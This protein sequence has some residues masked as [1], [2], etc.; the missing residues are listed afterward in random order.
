M[1]AI[2]ELSAK[3]AP[4]IAEHPS[5][6]IM[7]VAGELS[8]DLLGAGLMQELRRVWPQLRFIGIGG[9]KMIEAGL[10][11]IEP[12]ESLSV[13]GLVEVVKVLPK[14]L[15]VR[16]E[17]LKVME[18]EAPIA[19]I[20]IDSPDFNL[21]VAKKIDR[22]EGIVT[23]QYV[24]PSIW[25]WREGRVKTI[26]RVIDRVLCLFPFEVE[27]YK[28]HGVDAVCVGHRM[29]DEIPLT[30]S[31][32]ASALALGIDA[33]RPYIALLPGSRRGE[34]ER[35]L[36]LF[37]EG[38]WLFY[39]RKSQYNFLIPAATP[40][41]YQMIREMLERFREEYRATFGEKIDHFME[42]L[43]LIEGGAREAMGS[44]D[45]VL[46]ASGTASL[47]A[48]LLKKPMV[49]AYRFTPFTAWI[50]PKIVKIR[51]FS[52]PNILAG[53][54][55]VPELFQEMVTAQKIA[56][57]LEENILEERYAQLL[58][59]F[60]KLHHSLRREADRAAANAVLEKILME[61]C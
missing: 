45:A 16:K 23:F 55:I 53:R 49:V 46:L 13:M 47:E 44:A 57:L 56:E 25:V 18:Q 38:C 2:V 17:L 58:P 11:S 3:L 43:L 52:L 10:E 27:L 34:V 28:K 24:S 8:G 9:P 7:L 20:G 40:T 54:E 48:M 1:R 59:I 4:L 42:R 19:Y 15:G 41:I 26:K 29:G 31:K 30:T 36:P 51:L 39:Q 6:A 14:L 32:R 35:L 21:R 5:P 61:R 12:L 33:D 37:L 50:A 22:K 60:T